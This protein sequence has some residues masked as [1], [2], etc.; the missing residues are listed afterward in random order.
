MSATN[1]AFAYVFN[2]T[3]EDTKVAKVLSGWKSTDAPTI[4]SLA[5][6][7]AATRSR[8]RQLRDRLF[9]SSMHF[10]DLSHRKVSDMCPY[11]SRMRLCLGTLSVEMPEVLLW[12]LTLTR[13]TKTPNSDKNESPFSREIQLINQQ[14]IVI[15]QLLE[16]NREQAAKFAELEKLRL[17][18]TA[19]ETHSL[20]NAGITE[21][22]KEI[23][24]AN[25][26]TTTGKENGK[27]KARSSSK[28]T[29]AL[30]F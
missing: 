17:R 1:K 30:F 15:S 3:R 7:D 29:A 4:P 19:A 9:A 10:A 13:S 24:L 6:F 16:A 11:T 2:T 20:T 5:G 28:A 21:Q 12:S 22:S 26:S 23:N 25:D 27:R 18:E 14:N 8:I